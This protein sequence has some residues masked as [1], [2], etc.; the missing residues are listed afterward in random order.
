[1]SSGEVHCQEA[2][3]QE[4]PLFASN[5]GIVNS[6]YRLGLLAIDVPAGQ[7]VSV[8]VI[9][10]AAF[11]G[12]FLVAVPSG[13]W[14]KQPAK[15]VLNAACF[16]KRIAIE[17][18]VTLE[19][20]KEI[21]LDD[22]QMK[23][24]AGFLSEDYYEA[25]DWSQTE[26]EADYSF[27]ASR[28]GVYWPFADSL[29]SLA[30]E[31]FSF[32]TASEGEA[33]KREVNLE[34]PGSA[35]LGSRMQ[36]LEEIVTGISHAVATMASKSEAMDRHQP[37]LPDGGRVHFAP[38]TSSPGGVQLGHAASSSTRPGALRKGK[39]STS[40]QVGGLD[41]S[42]VAAGKQAGLSDEVLMQV[43]QLMS[44]NPKAQQVKDVN[45]GLRLDPL[46]ENE[47]EDDEV[48]PLEPSAADGGLAAS[49]GD[50]MQQAVI[51]LAGIMQILTEDKKKKAS[52]KLE[53][54]LDFTSSAGSESSGL[55]TG[56]R[57]AA[58]RRALRGML[59]E[60]PVEISSLVEKMMMEDMLSQTLPPGMTVAPS[61]S[62][63]WVEH[64]S[65][66]GSYRTLAHASWGV[67]GALDALIQGNVAQAR[68][69]LA[70]LLLQLDQSATDRG[71][72]TLATELSLEQPPPFSALMQHQP[73]GEG[74]PPYSKLLD[75]RWAEIA[76]AHIKEQDEYL[77]KRKQLGKPSKSDGDQDADTYKK[78]PKAKAKA[79]AAT[80]AEA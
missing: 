50:P 26:V 71:S 34:E 19:Q 59:L 18:A 52:S 21:A 57:S 73:P 46:S 65:R 66:I 28:A 54:A 22:A 31:Q 75:P 23:L 47:E 16:Q 12:K 17:V 55:G 20:D 77:S 30:N 56:K 72:W 48:I 42:V 70:V 51:H 27:E 61:S 35:D 6:D 64:R 2:L 53:S 40:P 68:A 1:M 3:D 10:I 5:E 69:R 13:A 15:R 36:K 78:R 24:W 58:A 79:K 49:T 76:L 11:S 33:P 29:V 14:H 37:R 7:T 9:P 62:R 8:Q 63:A 67:A 60:H 41:Q 80:D 4:D 44:R 38:S 32:F 25:V 74:E 39:Q 43:S 45:A